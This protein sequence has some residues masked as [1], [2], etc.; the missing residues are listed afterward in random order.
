MPCDNVNTAIDF[1]AKKIYN[2]Y[3]ISTLLSNERRKGTEMKKITSLLV[4]LIMVFA[5][6]SCGDDSSQLDGFIEIYENSEPTM[7]TTFVTQSNEKIGEL[8]SSYTYIIYEDGFEIKYEKENLQIPGLGVNE[9]EHIKTTVGQLLYH[10]GLFSTDGG[11]TWITEAPGSAGSVVKFDLDAADIDEEACEISSN[12][13]TLTVVLSAEQ[14][15]ALLGTTVNADENG[16]ELFFEHDG[17]N[18]RKINITYTS[19]S[20]DTVSIVTS[21]TYD[22]VTSPFAPPVEDEPAAE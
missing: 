4:A 5:L 16:V 11:K 19:V 3:N 15:T 10:D 22:A 20:G 1:F 8:V 6:F 18:L 14:A 13:K 12:Q 9:N 2:Y 21:Y 7:I 17:K